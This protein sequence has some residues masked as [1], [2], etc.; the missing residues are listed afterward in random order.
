MIPSHRFSMLE[1]THKT[2]EPVFYPEIKEVA[3]SPH[4]AYAFFFF[5]YLKT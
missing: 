5:F 1:E 2:F 3:M 4:H